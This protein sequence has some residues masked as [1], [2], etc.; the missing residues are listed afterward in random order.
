[1]VLLLGRGWSVVGGRIWR[2]GTSKVGIIGL[3]CDR[4]G[5]K[6]LSGRA[7]RMVG[8]EVTGAWKVL[9]R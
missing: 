3:A 4:C 9:S 8:G 6:R 2:G 1:M 7:A 5:I